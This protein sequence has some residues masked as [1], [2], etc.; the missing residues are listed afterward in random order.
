VAV[1]R[2]EVVDGEARFATPVR[3]DDLEPVAT[4]REVGGFA[5]PNPVLGF[6]DAVDGVSDDDLL[7][8]GGRTE[9]LRSRNLGLGPVGEH[10]DHH[11]RPPFPEEAGLAGAG[12]FGNVMT[13][14]GL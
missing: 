7:R 6:D 4:A 3:G 10:R 11:D 5:V 8:L 14:G 2:H 9:E 12:V 1:A 13:G